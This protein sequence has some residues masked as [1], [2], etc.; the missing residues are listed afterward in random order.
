[1]ISRFTLALLALALPLTPLPVLA[2]ETSTAEQ[3]VA[4]MN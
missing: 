2:D 4:V 1:M 3:V